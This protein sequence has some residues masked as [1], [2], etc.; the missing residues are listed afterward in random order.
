M[1]NSKITTYVL[2]TLVLGVWGY[3]IYVVLTKVSDNN[4][5][6]VHNVPKTT[7]PLN[8]NYYQWKTSLHYNDIVASPFGE[9]GTTQLVSEINE[10][11]YVDENQP[12]EN[13]DELAYAPAVDIQYL[14]YIENERLKQKV[15][16]VQINGKQQYMR[17]KQSIDGYTLISINATEIEFKTNLQVITIAKQ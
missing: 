9:N 14:G 15:A 2:L 17:T 16:I 7:P 3:V 10:G 11:Q 5:I 6:L 4:E 1:K 8:L 12:V 13:Y